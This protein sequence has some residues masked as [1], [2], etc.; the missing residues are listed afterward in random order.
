MSMK[1]PRS[2]D[3]LAQSCDMPVFKKRKILSSLGED[4]FYVCSYL[5]NYGHLDNPNTLPKIIRLLN[6]GAN[7]NEGVEGWGGHWHFPLIESMFRKDLAI[8]IVLLRYGALLDADH[9]DCFVLAQA[10]LPFLRRNRLSYAQYELF[11]AC[12]E[13]KLDPNH[14]YTIDECRAMGISSVSA[15]LIQEATQK[16]NDEVVGCAQDD[17]AYQTG[18]QNITKFV[19]DRAIGL[20]KRSKIT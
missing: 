1:R 8:T 5:C 14:V 15:K 13:H 19:F 12:S 10:A 4:L 7:P 17:F 11:K 2:Y 20:S 9:G 3:D 16:V 6:K 18:G